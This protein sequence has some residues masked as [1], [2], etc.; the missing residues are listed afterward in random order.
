MAESTPPAA[1]A[2]AATAA[3]QKHQDDKEEEVN[4]RQLLEACQAGD[5][6]RVQA[7][8]G[9]GAPAYYQVR[10]GRDRQG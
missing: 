3:Q 5:A 6:A 9:G 8:L 2:A 4:G 7:L 10:E 1:A